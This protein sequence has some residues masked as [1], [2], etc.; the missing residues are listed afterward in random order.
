[1]TGTVAPG[2]GPHYELRL[3]G[4]LDEHWSTWFD[5]LTLHHETDGTT[6]LTGTVT[7]Q[8]ELHGLLSKVRDLGATLIS[9]RRRS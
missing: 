3:E 4:H 8:A 6:T 1:M 2:D 9:V 7:D 5:G